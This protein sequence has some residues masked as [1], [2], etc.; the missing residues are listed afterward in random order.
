[1]RRDMRQAVR[2]GLRRVAQPDGERRGAMLLP[3][4]ARPDT[5]GA[6]VASLILSQAAFA[7]RDALVP[8]P[9]PHRPTPGLPAAEAVARRLGHARRVP[10]GTSRKVWHDEALSAPLRPVAPPEGGR[11]PRRDPRMRP[12]LAGAR[13]A[14]AGDVSS[15]GHSV[16]AMLQ[17]E[18]WRDA[19]GAPPVEAP[20]RTPGIRRGPAGWRP[21]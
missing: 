16:A 6:G 2:A 4:R 3:I 21:E 9:A 17:G 5:D 8:R 11:R 1:M 20:M 10:L 7:V 15:T 18:G 12:L 19:V 13:A 14:G